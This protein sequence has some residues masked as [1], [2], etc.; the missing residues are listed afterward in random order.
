MRIVFDTNVVIAGVVATGLCSEVL[1]AHLPLHEPVL[2]QVLWDELVTSLQEKFEL[3]I[4][5][6]PILEL[7]R[8][9]ALWVEPQPLPA[10][11]CRDSDDDWVLATAAAGDATLIVTGDDDLLTLGSYRGIEIVSPRQFLETYAFGSG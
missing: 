5:N 3:A 7:Y 1:E 11:I 4:E 9:H 6:L 10:P 2:S 8:R